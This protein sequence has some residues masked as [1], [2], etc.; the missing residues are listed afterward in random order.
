MSTV[1]E[2]DFLLQFDEKGSLDEFHVLYVLQVKVSE[3][4][5]KGTSG[6]NW[7]QMDPNADDVLQLVSKC[8]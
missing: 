5:D 6:G 8:R 1:N 2:F 4:I 3:Y 7:I